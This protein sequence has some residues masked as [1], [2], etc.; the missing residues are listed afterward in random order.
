MTHAWQAIFQ[1]SVRFRHG[2][3]VMPAAERGL[4]LFLVA[5]T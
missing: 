2:Y 1:V 5:E 4:A 3:A